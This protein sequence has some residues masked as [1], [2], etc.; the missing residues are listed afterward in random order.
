VSSIKGELKEKHSCTGP[1]FFSL[2]SPLD[3]ARCD[4]PQQFREW[5]SVC[6]KSEELFLSYNNWRVA[7]MGN[8]QS[9]IT[10][11]QLSCLETIQ[12]ESDAAKTCREAGATSPF[13]SA[14]A[15]SSD[16]FP[17]GEQMR[18]C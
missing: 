2:R 18:A 4:L 16:G 8:F 6:N 7:L 11:Q 14:K 17:C 10:A 1:E 13:L 9:E 15:A 12:Q 3:S 5:P